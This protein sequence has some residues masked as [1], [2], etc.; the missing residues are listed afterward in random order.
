MVASASPIFTFASFTERGTGGTLFAYLNNGPSSLFG[1]T[2]TGNAADVGV[3]A[4]GIPILFQYQTILGSLPGPLQGTLLAHMIMNAPVAGPASFDFI[5][6]N[7]SERIGGSIFITL[8]TPYLGQNNLLTVSFTQSGLTG[9]DGGGVA[10]VSG[11]TGG[12]GPV[13][14]ISFTSDFINFGTPVRD[15]L[16]MSFTSVAPCFTVGTGTP[17]GS[18]CNQTGIGT[19]LETFVATGTGSFAA[20]P[21]PS[22]FVPEPLTTSLTG[23]GLVALG[24]IGKRKFLRKR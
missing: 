15:E 17:D 21:E 10:D 16:T 11:D 19:Y 2:N 18:G 8:D 3:G 7:S 20:N 13:Q 9:S 23:L 1:T 5:S 24:Y 6:G 14:T 4:P 22:T 12:K